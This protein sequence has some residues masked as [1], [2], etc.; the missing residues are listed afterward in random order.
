VEAVLTLEDAPSAQNVFVRYII[1]ANFIDTRANNA[2][3][4]PYSI[5]GREGHTTPPNAENR[6][7][8]AA[9]RKIGE[10]YSALLNDYLSR[11]L[12]KK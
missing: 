5:Q 11:L 10:E 3:L 6:A 7:L 9:E 1:T 2:V 8:L 4:V 12:P